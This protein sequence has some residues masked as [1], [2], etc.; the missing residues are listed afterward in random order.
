MEKYVMTLLLLGC[1]SCSEFPLRQYYYVNQVL[2]WSDAQGYCREKYTDLATF[3]SMDDLNTLNADFSYTW[4]WIG[5]HDDPAAWK[6]SMGN[7]SNSWRWSATGQTSRTGFQLWDIYSPDYY[8]GLETCAA[9]AGGGLWS[10]SNCNAAYTF[11]CFNVTDQ[12]MKNY[13][14]VNE[15]MSW[16]SAQ[17]FCRENYTDLAMIEN[18]EENTEAQDAKPSSSLVWIG[19]YREPWTWSDGSL[20]SFRNWYPSGLNNYDGNQHCVTENPEH[21]W[22]DDLCSLKRT[23]VCQQVS[24]LKTSFRMKFLTDADLIDP[25]VNAQILQQLSA[26]LTEDRWTHFKLQWTIQLQNTP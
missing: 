16:S 19:L 4:A 3:D 1:I 22:A 6:T 11:L 17:E 8:E 12:N 9:I 18:Q 23:F 26:L 21:E 25:K 7:E 24:K 2:N 10:D 13:I 5:L 14:F 20:S 15:T